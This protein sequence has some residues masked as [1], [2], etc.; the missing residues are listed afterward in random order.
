MLQRLPAHFHFTLR[1]KEV[2][3]ASSARDLG[4]QVDSTLNVD[5]HITNTVSSTLQIATILVAMAP[6]ILE[7]AT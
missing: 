2:T 4:L 6:E 3:I 1:G 5:E 7:L